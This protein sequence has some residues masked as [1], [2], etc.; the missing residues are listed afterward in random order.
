[1]G[2]RNRE[3]PRYEEMVE[4]AIARVETE[5]LMG[6][7]A[8]PLHSARWI[9]I[10][11]LENDPVV[12]EPWNGSP[13]ERTANVEKRR[14]AGFYGEST[15]TV[16]AT[17]RYNFIG[18]VCD[19]AVKTAG[20]QRRSISDRIDAVVIHRVLGI[21]IFLAAMFVV[22]WAV[23]SVAAVP[24]GWIDSLARWTGTAVSSWWPAGPTS[25]LKSLLVD[26]VIGGVGNVLVFLPTSSSFS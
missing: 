20:A 15:E 6:R 9:A 3:F 21:P 2:W 5:I 12:C 25:L 26:G 18:S 24:S 14:I 1:M 17:Q 13:V 11:L 4:D 10:K 22:F 7:T 16:L 19:S 23:F 8:N